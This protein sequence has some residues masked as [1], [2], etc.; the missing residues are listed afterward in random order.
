MTDAQKQAELFALNWL[1][2]TV[3]AL[4]DDSN[5]VRIESKSVSGGIAF[6]VAV[7]PSDLGKVIGKQ[8]RNARALRSIFFAMS[9]KLNARFELDIV[10]NTADEKTHNV[11]M[12]D[13]HLVFKD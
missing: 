1:Q 6:K 9:K 3:H 10:K 5:A 7:L 13:E 2:M 8:G 4:V 11:F 12:H